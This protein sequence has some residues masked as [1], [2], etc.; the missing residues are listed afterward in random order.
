MVAGG[1]VV[2]LE[3]AGFAFGVE[4]G[5]ILAI[6]GGWVVVAVTGADLALAGLLLYFSRLK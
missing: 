5:A 2:G 6:G 3:G 4:V 1:F